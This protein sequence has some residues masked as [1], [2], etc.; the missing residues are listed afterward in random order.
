M[1]RSCFHAE[2]IY[3]V[4]LRQAAW[5]SA[6][7]WSMMAVVGYYAGVWSDDLIRRGTSV[8]FTRKMMQV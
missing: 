1:R 8:T 3:R 7:P 6:V 2:Q 5:F 4:D